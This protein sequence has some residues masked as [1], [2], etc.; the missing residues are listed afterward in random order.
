MDINEQYKNIINKGKRLPPI[1][2]LIN[3]NKENAMENYIL[4]KEQIKKEYEEREEK[5]NQQEKLKQEQE[6]MTKQLA[7]D[8][9]EEIGKELKK[10]NL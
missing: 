2:Y 4:Q 1:Y 7:E 6:K 5:K 8:I 9:A 10:L 3:G